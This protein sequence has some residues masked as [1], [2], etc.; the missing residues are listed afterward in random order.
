MD[1]DVAANTAVVTSNTAPILVTD[2]LPVPVRSYKGTIIATILGIVAYLIALAIAGIIAWTNKDYTL[3]ILL[4]GVAAANFTTIMTYW[5]GSSAGSA[6]KTDV[7]AA[8]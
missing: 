4:A 6:Y 7:L 3:L 8:K 5:V 2:A 1:I